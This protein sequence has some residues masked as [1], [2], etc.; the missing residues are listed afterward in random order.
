MG[1]E[2]KDPFGFDPLVDPLMKYSVGYL[3]HAGFSRYTSS[4]IYI[5]V[6]GGLFAYKRG[7]TSSGFRIHRKIKNTKIPLKA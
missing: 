7:A 1:Q 2:Q 6:L 5:Y 3:S 4:R